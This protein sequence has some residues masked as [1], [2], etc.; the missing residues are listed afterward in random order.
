[1]GLSLY[2]PLYFHWFLYSYITHI[3]GTAVILAGEPKAARVL[4]AE[5]NDRE[6]HAVYLEKS[7][8][9]L[10]LKVS[11]GN[12]ERQI[13]AGIQKYYKPEE[14]IGRKL[15]IV[16]NLAPRKMRGLESQGMVIAAGDGDVVK[17][18]F[19]DDAVEAG[20]SVH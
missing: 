4:T 20:E 8:K 2:L 1:M 18:L 12:E 13:L 7:D 5:L 11:L 19:V 9:L 15:V 3:K 14:L 6:I 17:V 10:K 16:A